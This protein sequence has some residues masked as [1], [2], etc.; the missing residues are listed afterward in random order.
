MNKLTPE[1]RLI[2]NMAANTLDYYNELIH[3]LRSLDP[4]KIEYNDIDLFKNRLP[5]KYNKIVADQKTLTELKIINDEEFNER[6][7]LINRFVKM[8]K[9]LLQ[10]YIEDK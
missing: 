5:R 2:S 7:D 1:Q 6:Q 3:L 8:N 9:M 4:E 10:S